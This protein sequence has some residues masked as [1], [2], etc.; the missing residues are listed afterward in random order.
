MT[1]FLYLRDSYLRAFQ[2]V[3]TEHDTGQNGVRLDRSAFYPGGGGQ[4]PDRGWLRAQGAEWHVKTARRGGLHI[5]AEGE[6]PPIGA[7]VQAELDWARRYPIMR[8]HTAMHIL[9]G[10][11]W[12]D[13][14]ASVTGGNMQVLSGRMDFEFERLSPETVS[15][16][17]AKIN[18]EVANARPVK[19]DILPRAEA[20][21]IPD[22]IRTKINLLPPG[23]KEV[24]TVE[25]VGLD[26]QADGG[27]HVANTSEVGRITISKY[28][29]KGGINK[30]LYVELSD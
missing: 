29:S 5:I 7:T 23:I 17:E 12:R 4:E 10:V 2:A 11:I 24:R 9:C 16:I 20:F 22:L 25:I 26:L 3:V 6:L 8:T 30:R 28:K 15:D 13:Y 1:D 18:Q 19:I 14:Q 27:T 21:Q